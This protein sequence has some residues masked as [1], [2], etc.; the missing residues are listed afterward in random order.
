MTTSNVHNQGIVHLVFAFGQ[1]PFCR[2]RR[3][4]MCT[5]PA[6]MD[7]WPRICVKC[8][9]ALNTMRARAD[10]KSKTDPEHFAA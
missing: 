3:A 2:S 9:N 1:Q 5:V 6:E 8:S 4:I 10:A 7:R